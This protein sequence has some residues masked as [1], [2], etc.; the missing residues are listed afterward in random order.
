MN[1]KN[2]PSAPV[3]T[4]QA[5]DDDGLTGFTEHLNMWAENALAFAELTDEEKATLTSARDQLKFY[6]DS[7]KR[8]L[9]VFDK[10]LV[11][12]VME[13]AFIIGCDGVRSR[14]TDRLEK[15]AENASMAH[16][17]AAIERRTRE[18]DEK[19]LEIARPLWQRLPTK[20]RTPNS[21]ATIISQSNP[22]LGGPD[23]IRK[24]LKDLTDAGQFP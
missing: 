18:K 15:A 2:K 9:G 21:L 22:E 11:G 19:L 12:R 6:V 14:I 10:H 1:R 20:Q 7:L 8:R 16:A 23:G 5:P 24:R 4:T 3:I 17:R 13:A